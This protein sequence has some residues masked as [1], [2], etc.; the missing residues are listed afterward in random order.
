MKKI[1]EELFF[2]IFWGWPSRSNRARLDRLLAIPTLKI[3]KPSQKKNEREF[4]TWTASF[5]K[6]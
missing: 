3:P 6:H 1:L 4:S 2:G 5:L